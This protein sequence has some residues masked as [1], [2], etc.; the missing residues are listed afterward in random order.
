MTS[1]DCLMFL[2]FRKNMLLVTLNQYTVHSVNVLWL[3]A[4]FKEL[5]IPC[6]NRMLTKFLL[7]GELIKKLEKRQEMFLSIG[8]YSPYSRCIYAPCFRL[9]F[10][11]L[12]VLNHRFSVK[13]QKS[14]EIKIKTN[15]RLNLK[16]V[17]GYLFSFELRT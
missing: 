13:Q 7:V 8:Y 10:I 16:N 15:T 17:V 1:G 11:F 14:S 6:H 5:L 12:I 4:T 2:V 9:T 3:G